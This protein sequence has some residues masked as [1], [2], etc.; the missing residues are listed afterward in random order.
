M[1]SNVALSSKGLFGE[2]TAIIDRC[3]FESAIKIIWLCEQP[4]QENFTRYLADG[5]RTELELKSEI[6]SRIEARGGKTL[7]IE[8]RMLKSISN[9]ILAAE[10]TETDITSAKKLPNIASMI[11]SAGLSRLSYVVSQRLGSHHV[12]GTWP[13][14]L[15]HY[16]EEKEGAAGVRFALRDHDCPTHINQFMSVSR[17]LLRATSAYVKYAIADRNYSQ[18]FDDVLKSTRDEIMR[19]FTEAKGGNLGN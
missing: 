1:H 8:V 15:F 11:S 6:E 7:P 4:L 2:T 3:I 10:L 17:I 13:S 12:H 9:H 19:I 14:L 18:A 16:L 5:L